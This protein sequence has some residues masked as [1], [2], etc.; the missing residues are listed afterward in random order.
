MYR[1]P[2]DEGEAARA[3]GIWTGKDRRT[4]LDGRPDAHP[5]EMIRNNPHRERAIAPVDFESAG[6]DNS[7]F[8]VA[9]AAEKERARAPWITPSSEVGDED[10][11]NVARSRS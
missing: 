6:T 9:V 1:R 11:A 3:N 7:P 10:R 5:A 2:G 4:G 8:L